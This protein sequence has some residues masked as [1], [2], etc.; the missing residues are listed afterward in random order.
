M[1]NLVEGWTSPLQRQAKELKPN[2][3]LTTPQ[4]KFGTTS[5]KQ[6]EI[7]ISN[8]EAPENPS[9]THI[10]KRPAILPIR[11]EQLVAEVKGIYA[12]LA[13]VESRYIEV[14]NAQSARIHT[15][16]SND[17]QWQAIVALI[18]L[19]T[20]LQ[21]YED[22]RWT[23]QHPSGSSALRRLARKYWVP[24]RIWWH[25]T[26]PFLDLLRQRVPELL[27]HMLAF[28]CLAYPMMALL[29]ETVL[30]F[31]NVWIECLG[32]LGQCDRAV[33]GDDIRYTDIWAKISREKNPKAPDKANIG[34]VHH[35]FAIFGR[36]ESFQQL[37]LHPQSLRVAIPFESF[38]D[39]IL[40]LLERLIDIQHRG[41]NEQPAILLHSVF[42]A[43]SLLKRLYGC[44]DRL[45]HCKPPFPKP[46]REPPPPPSQT[47]GS[48]K[49]HRWNEI[50][51]PCVLDIKMNAAEHKSVRLGNSVRDWG[52]THHEPGNS[53]V[54]GAKDNLALELAAP[55]CDK[56]H[57]PGILMQG[58]YECRVLIAQVASEMAKIWPRWSKGFVWI[59][60]SRLQSG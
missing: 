17:R 42:D 39:G 29:Y 11:Q 15:P 32:D 47:T 44:L 23:S 2:S 34:R 40:T 26:H 7:D 33:E 24:A 20:L 54:F 27:K 14:D 28:I 60:E 9:V 36:L 3:T 48:S 22:F 41:Q 13:M 51:P 50:P 37:Y 45:R 8:I 1:A 31:A 35:H 30:I 16:R 21:R 10:I 52:W 53:S 55:G 43:H 49:S 46:N 58:L 18:R 5:P 6:V 59:P 12:G 4:S 25:G 57:K 19:E 56:H 38:R